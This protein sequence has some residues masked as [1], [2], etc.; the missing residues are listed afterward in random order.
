MLLGRDPPQQMRADADQGLRP[1]DAE[2]KMQ[3]CIKRLLIAA[4][5]ALLFAV[6]TAAL[7][8]L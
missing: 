7:P 8:Q 4:T 6:A 3:I 1:I 2:V 5:V